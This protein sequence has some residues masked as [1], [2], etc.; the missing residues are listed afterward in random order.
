MCSILIDVFF[1]NDQRWHSLNNLI[2]ILYVC[3][4]HFDMNKRDYRVYLTVLFNSFRLFRRRKCP[5][6]VEELKTHG[7]LCMTQ[8]NLVERKKTIK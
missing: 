6:S 3:M 4:L 8:V 5:I 1:H 7:S 2:R